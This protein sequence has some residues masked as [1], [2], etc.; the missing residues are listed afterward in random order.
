[1]FEVPK[2]LLEDCAV[3]SNATAPRIMSMEEQNIQ[4]GKLMSLFPNPNLSEQFQYSEEDKISAR[5]LVIL[6]SLRQILNS[7]NSV[8][9]K[10]EH[11]APDEWTEI[12]E[13]IEFLHR[14][15]II[16]LSWKKT[17]RI[18][19]VVITVQKGEFWKS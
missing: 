12:V 3:K 17:S 8:S 2:N 9:F 15:K 1:L 6:E 11:Y 18:D 16:L 4:G 19:N 5:A 14:K 13:S 7:S 10:R